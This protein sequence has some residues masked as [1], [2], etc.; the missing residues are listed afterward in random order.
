MALDPLFPDDLLIATVNLLNAISTIEIAEKGYLLMELVKINQLVAALIES[1]TQFIPKKDMTHTR[2]D[3]EF[4][5]NWL[6][7]FANMIQSQLGIFS[8]ELDDDQIGHLELVMKL[9][10]VLLKILEPYVNSSNLLPVEEQLAIC[11]HDC[12]VM[13]SWICRHKNRKDLKITR[14][15]VTIMHQ[16]RCSN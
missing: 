10:Q 13:T 16:L 14:V 9:E 5:Q 6:S 8:S 1:F 3:L 4:I 7:I 12:V 2:V 15:V 11:I